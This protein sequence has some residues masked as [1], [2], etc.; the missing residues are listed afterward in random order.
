MVSPSDHTASSPVRERA[1]EANARG[2]APLAR[3]DSLGRYIIL[4]L[5]GEGAMGSV[6]RAYDSELDRRVALKLL[7]AHTITDE[8]EARLL[9]EARALA[10]LAH[11]NIVT[12]FDA[13]RLEDRAFVA[14]ELVEGETLRAWIER[15][16][17]RW[18]PVLER[19]TRA[20]R[21]LAAAHA[22]GI[23]HGDF[24]PDNVLVGGDQR[25]LVADFGLAQQINP[26]DD[27]PLEN[28]PTQ[29]PVRPAPAGTP[30]YLAPE[31][32]D[33]APPSASADQFAFCVSLFEALFRERPFRADTLEGLAA[34]ARKGPPAR[35]PDEDVPAWLYDV[36]RKGLASDPA[37]RFASMRA[38]LDALPED[39][40]ADLRHSNAPRAL[41]VGAVVS[42]QFALGWWLDPPSRRSVPTSASGAQTLLWTLVTATI[43]GVVVYRFR[44]KLL[45]SQRSKQLLLSLGALYYASVLVEYAAQRLA[46][47][48]AFSV[49]S[50]FVWASACMLVLAITLHR[51]FAATALLSLI[52]GIVTIAAPALAPWTSRATPFALAL[53]LIAGW[54]ARRSPPPAHR[55]AR[56]P[57][58]ST[59]R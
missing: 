34:A 11:E 18:K 27:T 55:E 57:Y 48:P 41:L 19:F 23:V 44:S 45:A 40:E 35:A 9:R 5:L 17:P 2:G 26:R 20:A 46:A 29:S 50:S 32:F 21:G 24:K 1:A 6:Y 58:A 54:G 13:G 15:E 14:L 56:S 51:L 16:N 37:A 38:L 8:R 10:Q 39:P 59:Q 33:G 25:V 42:L 36:V 28:T 7:R 43:A 47:P 52:A 4:D 12:V 53:V 22:A 31:R 30:A 49:A 3:G